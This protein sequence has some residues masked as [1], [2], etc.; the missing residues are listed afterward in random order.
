MDEISPT[1]GRDQSGVRRGASGVSMSAVLGLAA[2]AGWGM[3]AYL[4]FVQLPAVADTQKVAYA[5]SLV[6]RFADSAPHQAYMRLGDS[7]K[8]WWD[9]IEDLQRQIAAAPTD[10]ARV[11]LITHRDEMLIAFIKEHN[12]GNDI[13]TLINSFDEF[14]RCLSIDACDEEALRKTIGVDVRRIYRTFH[15]YIQSVRESGRP[16]MQEFGHDLEELFFRFVG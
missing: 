4:Y 3:A 13:E 9:Q 15:P 1:T 11:A 7:M 5:L 8:P 16:G 6:D 10:E 14:A 12:L 2:V